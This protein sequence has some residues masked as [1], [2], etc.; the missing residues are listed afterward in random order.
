MFAQSGKRI[1]HVKPWFRYY[2]Q[3]THG[4]YNIRH[5]IRQSPFCLDQGVLLS[6]ALEQVLMGFCYLTIEP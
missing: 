4:L 6:S 2:D 5:E 1:N 3:V